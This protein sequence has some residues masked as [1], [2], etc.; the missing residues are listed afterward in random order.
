[1]DSIS[2]YQPDE[3]PYH[4]EAGTVSI[5]GI[6]GLNA[7]QKWFAE[8]G[9]GQL[10][11]AAA[12]ADHAQACAAALSYIDARERA[13]VATLENAFREMSGVTV[14]GP[15]HNGKRVATL[16][17]NVDAVPADQVG[18]M[19]DADHHVCVRSGL[20]CAP[21]V[22]EDEGTV[23]HKGTV[24]FAPGYFTDEEDLQQA[25]A[26]IRDIAS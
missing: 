3:Y 10:G 6:A 15:G 26:G 22:H 4:L 1:M 5:P 24:R 20:H 16:S 2:P 21:L 7:A 19:L 12:S 25:I 23:A 17:V 9:R 13:H 14:Y 18:A 11:E 8:L